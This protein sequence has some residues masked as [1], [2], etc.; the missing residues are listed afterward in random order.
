MATTKKKASKK[1]APPKGRAQRK[2]R[3]QCLCGA[4]A[5]EAALDRDHGDACHCGQCRRWSG[6]Y[7]A[8]VNV[9]F[10]SLK[11]K[12]GEE[13]LKWF[14]SSDLVRRGFCS[15][16]GSALFWHADR[17]KD[18]SHRIALALGAL[19]APTGVAISEHIFV[20]DK[21]DYYE[22]KD[23]LPQKEAY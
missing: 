23:G 4:V 9:P 5:F 12:K 17:H 14:R 22:I 19:A 20:A 21:G 10:A 3:G 13:R 6:N 15:R 8:S 16:C 7:W 18:H 2:A 11:V 1:S